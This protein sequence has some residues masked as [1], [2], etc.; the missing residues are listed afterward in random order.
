M[1]GQL[2]LSIAQLVIKCIPA[3]RAMSNETMAMAPVLHTHTSTILALGNPQ[4]PVFILEHI[5]RRA[6]RVFPVS[7][8]LFPLGAQLSECGL[9]V[10]GGAHVVGQYIERLFS[11]HG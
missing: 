3:L 1:I 6:S 9:E 10:L 4:D 11:A 5:S 2:P 8:H 7:V